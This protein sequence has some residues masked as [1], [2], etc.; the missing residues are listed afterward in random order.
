LIVAGPLRLDPASGDTWLNGGSIALTR[1]ETATPSTIFDPRNYGAKG[2]GKTLDTAA[3]NRAIDVCHAKGGGTVYLS[4]GTFL[5]GTV[6]LKSNV[7]FYL[8]AGATLLGSTRLSDY[9]VQHV[10]NPKAE[11]GPRHLILTRDTK[12]VTIAGP[13]RID[14]QG[15]AFWTHTPRP[16]VPESRIW[17]DAAHHDWKHGKRVSPMLELVNCTNLR[18]EGLTITG[19]RLDCTSDQLHACGYHRHPHQKSG[20]WTEYGRHRCHQLSG[21]SDLRQRHRYR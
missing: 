3:I 13:G 6:M 2:D 4:G 16:P 19:V 14:G 8:E 21:C 12:N 5:S 15:H 20:L 1:R 17:T 18:I 9:P 7:T 10:V 11:G